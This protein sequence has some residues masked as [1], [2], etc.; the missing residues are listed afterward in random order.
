MTARTEETRR[1]GQTRRN[2][3]ARRYEPAPTR[4]LHP[5]RWNP[6]RGTG[7]GGGDSIYLLYLENQHL[8]TSEIYIEFGQSTEYKKKG[9]SF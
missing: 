5:T 2:R 1:R 7:P 3:G 8:T 9:C 6:H 4:P